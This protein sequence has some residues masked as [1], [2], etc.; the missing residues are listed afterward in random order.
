MKESTQYILM[1]IVYHILLTIVLATF[2]VA[3]CNSER[4]MATGSLIAYSLLKCMWRLVCYDDFD[5][6]EGEHFGEDDT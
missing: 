5:D 1:L 3:C 4:I 2:T 6:C